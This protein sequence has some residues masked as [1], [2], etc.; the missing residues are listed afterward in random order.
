MT[1]CSSGVRGRMKEGIP[2]RPILADRHGPHKDSPGTALVARER[3]GEAL[4]R[5]GPEA[6]AVFDIRMFAAALRVEH[7][8]TGALSNARLTPL[9]HQI[10]LADKLLSR[11]LNAHLI[12]DDVGLGKTVEAG[13]IYLALAQRGQAERVLIVTPAGLT[14]QWREAM[15]SLFGT[16]FDVFNLD[17]F[18]S[19]PETWNRYPRVI[20]SIDAMKRNS[21]GADGRPGR[22]DVLADAD[23][24]DLVF[25]DEAHRLSAEESSR[26]TE[27]TQNYQLAET[28]RAKA[29]SFYLLTATPHQGRDDKFRHLLRL[30]DPMILAEDLGGAIDGQTLNRLMTRNRKSEVTDVDGKR[31]FRGHKVL[32]IDCPLTPAEAAF[33]DH[34]GRYIQE[35]YGTADALEGMMSRAIGFVMVTFQKLAASSLAAI[36]SALGKRH[37]NLRATRPALPPAASST[38]EPE[39]DDRFAGEQEERSPALAAT[40]AF[41]ADEVAKLADLLDELGRLPRDSKVD[42]LMDEVLNLDRLAAAQGRPPEHILIFT[43]YRASQDL[44]VSALGTVYGTQS[45]AIIRGG[46][47]LN[48]KRT[49]QRLFAT[50]TRF[51]ISTEAGGE[52]LNLQERSHILFNFDLP[53]NPT[54]LHQRIGRLDRYGQAEEVIAYNLQRTGTIE[55]R[56]RG[57][58]EE[59]IATIIEAL[60]E[61]EGDRVEDLREAV[62]GHLDQEVDLTHIYADALRKGTDRPS[63]SVVDAAMA[64]VSEAARRMAGLYGM[65]DRFDLRAFHDRSPRYQTADVEAFASRYLEHRGRRL[66]DHKDG[67]FSFLMPDE[68]RR[69]R[70]DP[71]HLDQVVFDQ[72]RLKVHPEARLLGFGDEFF[73]RMVGD[74]LGPDFGGEVALRRV[75]RD[76]E[77][78]PARGYQFCFLVR[79]RDGVG[80]T[81][82]DLDF[83]GFFLDDSLSPDTA[84]GDRLLREWSAHPKGGIA[85]TENFGLADEALRT[86]Q[87]LAEERLLS[88]SKDLPGPLY[89][90]LLYGSAVVAFV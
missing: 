32:A 55:D 16:T 10:L 5:A 74:C 23:S 21:R 58:L 72:T 3:V 57:Y 53:W 8:R 27:R 24:W 13:M 35:G 4:A 41:F 75:P 62:L 77:D 33:Y 65:L 73:D 6:A 47:T 63:R 30:V 61:L 44:L 22:R 45:C 11:G 90:L 2:I 76:G 69:R 48:E 20:A 64:S 67:S 7:L 88:L 83:W 12:A 60:R 15:E 14:L 28:L 50:S 29:R 86:A 17:F 56:L 82:V 89:E 70:L 71:K 85:L 42:R 18:D 40:P 81:P 9:P 36:G 59:K 54:R 49:A 37:A 31:L 51:L 19:R 80:S 46:M 39:R 84:R 66:K 38:P 26:G 34:L 25:F 68:L 52:G 87:A 78:G 43:E 1:R 79:K